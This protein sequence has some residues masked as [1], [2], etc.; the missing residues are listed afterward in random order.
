MS[1]IT[2]TSEHG[3]T[4]VA[5]HNGVLYLGGIA[6][7]DLTTGLADQTRQVLEEVDRVLAGAG[8]SKASILQARVNLKDFGDKDEMNRVWREWLAGHELPA[9]STN[10]SIEM[11]DGV[12][13]EV[14]IIA[15]KED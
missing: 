15:A 5:E 14:V 7:N 1:N 6:A 9:R 4:S 11:G 13:I 2:R 12:L 3:H 8:S 10:G